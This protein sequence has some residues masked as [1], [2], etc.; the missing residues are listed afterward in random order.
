MSS[1]GSQPGKL[2]SA[3]P[4]LASPGAVPQPRKLRLRTLRFR[5]ACL[6]LACVLPVWIAGAILV[7]RTYQ[8]QRELAEQRVMETTRALSLVVDRELAA[9]RASDAALATSP[10]LVSGDLAAFHRQAQAVLND[11]PSAV[12]TLADGTGQQLVNSLVPFGTRLPKHTAWAQVQRVFETGQPVVLDLYK[13]AV[14]GR[15]VVGIGVPVTRDGRVIYALTLTAPVNR[16]SELLQKSVPPTWP[17]VLMDGRGAVVARTPSGEKF[18]GRPAVPAFFKLASEVPEGIFTAGNLEGV[19]VI[20]PFK[21]GA[22]SGWTVSIGIPRAELLAAIR[23]WLWWTVGVVVLLSLLG[24]ALAQH[25]ARRIAG[26]IQALAG[27][28]LALGTGEPVEVGPLDLAE[29][30][31]VGQSLVKASQ[32]LRQ[33][34][35]ER[36][37]AEA[38]LQA[39]NRTLKAL[40]NVNQAL[41]HASDERA[42]LEEVCTIIHRDGGY[43]MAWAGFAEDDP[44]KTV[45]P[46]AYAGFEES[47]LE[48]ARLSWGD[49]E[50][51]RG[52]AGIAIR[53]QRSCC[54]RNILTDPQFEPWRAEAIKRGYS[55]GLALPLIQADKAFGVVAVYSD[56]PDGFPPEELQLLEE[57]ACDLAYG[58]ATLRSRAAHARAEAALRASEERWS[59]TLRSIGD[60]VLTTDTQGRVTFLNPVAAALTGWDA[61]QAQGKPVEAIF[62]IVNEETREP[63]E[64]IVAR[65]LKVGR[66]VELANHTALVAVDGREIPIEDSAAPI[67][68]NA[69]SIAGVVLVFHDVTEKRRKDDELQQLNR[70]LKALGSSN[71]VLLRATDE[72]ALLDQVCKVITDDCG[73]A[74]VWIGLAEDGESKSVRPIA[75][76]GFE[77]GYLESLRVTWAD[78]ERGRGPTGSAIRTGR[79]CA[80]RNMLTDATFEPWRAEALKRGYASSLALPLMEDE[81]AFGAITI[82]SRQPD[83]FSE[84]EMGLLSELTAD[85]AY[86]T[87]ALRVR[88]ARALAEAELRESK[89]RL[90][91]ALEVA[92]LGEWELDLK[93]RSAFRSL[94]HAQIFGY[95]TVQREWKYETFVEHVLPHDRAAVE[96]AVA[97]GIWNFETRIRR[98]DG[99]LRWIWVRGRAQLDETG[100]PARVLGTVMDITERKRADEILQTTLQ[101]FYAILSSTYSGI[102]LVTDN[103]RVEFANQSFC[104]LFALDD[105]PDALVGLGSA[106]MLE[107]IKH[108]YRYP[109]EALQRIHQILH[110]GEA[111]KGE[112]LAMQSGRTCL[113]DYIPLKV[114]GKS[115][116]RLWLHTDITQRKK[117]EARLQRFYETDL[118]AILYWTLDGGVIEV[119]DKFL[120]MTGYARDDLRAGRLNWARMTPPEY[121]GMDEDARRQIRETGIHLPYEKEFIRKDGTRVWGQFS[122]AAWEDNRNEGVSFILDIT[123]RKRAEEALLRSEKLASVGRMAAVVAHE[124]NNPLEAVTNLLYLIG[125]NK[126]LPESARQFLLTAEDELMRI[127]HITRQS[128]GFYRESNAPARTSINALLESAVDLLKKKVQTKQAVIEKQWDGDIEI[129]AVAG[130]LRQVFSNLLANS[131][132]AIGDGGTVKLRISVGNAPINGRRSIRVTVAD[133]GQGIAG[134]ARSHIFEPFYTTKGTTG[135]GLGL[136]VSKQVIEK[137][138][139]TIR[140]RSCTSGA[141]QGT[142]FSLVL[143]L[144]A[145]ASAHASS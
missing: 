88:A 82:Y 52:P 115:Y 121:H 77:E 97:R 119:N 8:Q 89:E 64:N 68:D 96:E 28:A 130:E 24:I 44:Q 67:R 16:F 51:G 104:N 140:V 106:P 98:E 40:T 128:L 141:R 65:V 45:C 91:L 71:Q 111:V 27:P 118:F 62:R 72:A 39:V 53:T 34:T 47:Y 144:N 126:E 19:P 107:K 57:L 92:D 80:C 22:L 31:E 132:D 78:N 15:F 42:L 131:L 100:Q 137:H 54:C 117:A 75:H 125:A 86:G 50:Y 6:V 90:E 25:L 103:G 3:P 55:S 23:Q 112:E 1:V 58:I 99:E 11:Y 123:E 105:A 81:K 124:I 120:Q 139:G 133:N 21:R 138:G 36:E 35:A 127:A 93:N 49:N 143:P 83:G 2:T 129:M 12:L 43:S 76:A 18:I 29:T 116:G 32:L 38:Q 26:S 134:P 69:G 114:D 46:V 85:L 17:V 74:M 101:R 142:T 33:R 59:T 94:R 113:R 10:S 84:R 30:C 20:A 95:S 14:A 110:C 41:V 5:L 60:A 109:D 37:Q 66:V 4:E 73:Y 122:A 79:P 56:Q 145:A 63:A 102:L 61:E 135:T 48:T 108:G 70:T 87:I 13:G 9:M 136:W 7:Y